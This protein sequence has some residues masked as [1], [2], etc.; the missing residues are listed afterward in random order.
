MYDL[1]SFQ[2]WQILAGLLDQYTLAGNDEAFK[3]MT[4]MVDYFY[5]RV[6]NVVS[7]YTVERHYR[8]L[9]EETGG[10]NDVL[11]RL[12]SITVGNPYDYFGIYLYYCDGN[13][14]SIFH[15][16]VIR[17]IQSIYCWL[18]SLINPVF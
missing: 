15:V 5:K 8:S 3:M 12:Y 6:Q 10:M 4:W 7:K 17:Q 2:L 16:D 13:V 9:N 1:L 11:Y 18:T 14:T